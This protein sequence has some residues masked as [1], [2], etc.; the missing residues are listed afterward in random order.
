M[1]GLLVGSSRDPQEPQAASPQH[2]ANFCLIR[3]RAPAPSAHSARGAGAPRRC[4]PRP[5]APPST[6][7]C[8]AGAGGGAQ[9][10]QKQ[11]SLPWAMRDRAPPRPPERSCARRASAGGRSAMIGAHWRSGRSAAAA[12]PH[13]SAIRFGVARR[14]ARAAPLPRSAKPTHLSPLPDASTRVVLPAECQPSWA[15]TAATRHPHPL[16]LLQRPPPLDHKVPISA[17]FGQFGQCRPPPQRA[18]LLHVFPERYAW[19]ERNKVAPFALKGGAR[20]QRWRRCDP[21]EQ[22]QFGRSPRAARTPL[23]PL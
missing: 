15:C 23:P 3:K 11:F 10:V 21:A 9:S 14:A 7:R 4:V 17:N 1:P 12:G 6:G 22:R 2:K 18:A 16:N 8:A 13:S 20:A 5:L 19:V